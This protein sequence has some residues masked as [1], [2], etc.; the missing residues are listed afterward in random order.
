MLNSYPNNNIGGIENLHELITSLSFYKSLA[1]FPNNQESLIEKFS[2][3]DLSNL[4]QSDKQIK[5]LN[6]QNTGKYLI[7]QNHTTIRK[8]YIIVK[9]KITLKVY[10]TPSLDE[11]YFRPLILGK[12]VD[13]EVILGEIEAFEDN[14]SES[15]SLITAEV[16][17]AYPF[18]GFLIS[19]EM[20]RKLSLIQEFSQ[21]VIRNMSKK[22][23]K[24]HKAIIRYGTRP[25]IWQKTKVVYEIIKILKRNRPTSEKIEINQSSLVKKTKL[26]RARINQ[27]IRRELEEIIY[28][29]N[30]KKH[31]YHI[32]TCIDLRNYVYKNYYPFLTFFNE[33]CP[34]CK[35]NDC[36][37]QFRF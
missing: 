7:Q 33:I 35:D 23:A 1:D 9:G 36:R 8:V 22:L 20:F 21:W 2:L 28:Y 26:D 3:I 27:I 12:D 25:D 32:K 10:V 13:E 6:N 5:I 31:P 18:S 37:K 14:Q 16:D 24:R 29:D 19:K 4:S 30:E 15:L 17:T 11:E 34:H